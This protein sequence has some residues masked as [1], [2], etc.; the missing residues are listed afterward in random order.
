MRIMSAAWAILGGALLLLVVSAV[1][2]EA[3]DE[4]PVPERV[5]FPSADGYTALVGYLYKPARCRRRGC[6]RW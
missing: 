1:S 4:G 3:E 6:R 2:V 5:T